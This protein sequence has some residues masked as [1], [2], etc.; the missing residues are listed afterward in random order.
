MVN[1]L[2]FLHPPL[3]HVSLLFS[4]CMADWILDLEYYTQVPNHWPTPSL[5]HFISKQKSLFTRCPARSRNPRNKFL[6]TGAEWLRTRQWPGVTLYSCHQMN[7]HLWLA[8][9]RKDV[10]RT[11]RRYLAWN[12]QHF[13]KSLN[14][15]IDGVRGGLTLQL[16]RLLKGGA[17]ELGICVFIKT[18]W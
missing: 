10:A 15:L 13:P 8:L 17:Q 12:C 5:Y 2:F 3:L 16:H 11:I 7:V 14:L 1:L 4:S 6:A 18:F 9:E